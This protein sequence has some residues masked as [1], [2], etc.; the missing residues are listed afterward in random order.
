MV[1]EISLHQY[2]NS[3]LI[4]RSNLKTKSND[5][6]NNKQSIISKFSYHCTTMRMINIP[7]DL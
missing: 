3:L 7:P 6:D 4:S 1:F 2:L 5:D